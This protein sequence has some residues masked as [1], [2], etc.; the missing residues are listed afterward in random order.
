MMPSTTAGGELMVGHR[1]TAVVVGFQI[2][3]V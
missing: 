3:K 1:G 2:C